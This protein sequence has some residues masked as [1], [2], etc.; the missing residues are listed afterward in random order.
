[1]VKYI[2]K[3]NNYLLKL[4]KK[5]RRKNVSMDPVRVSLATSE[6][7]F[8]CLNQLNSCS[9]TDLSWALRVGWKSFIQSDFLEPHYHGVS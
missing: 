9:G 3:T 7:V 8:L 5:H 2:D 6:Q 1:M 4:I